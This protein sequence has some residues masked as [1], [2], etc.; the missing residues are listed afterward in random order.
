MA[1]ST[2]NYKLIKPSEDDFYDVNQ[3]NQNADM[4]DQGMKTNQEQIEKMKRTIQARLLASKWS[5]TAP[6]TQTVSVA[7][8]TQ[9]DNPVMLK[10]LTGSESEAVVKA[11]NKAYGFLVSGETRAGSIV[12]TAYKK[13]A[14]DFDIILKGV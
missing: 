1:D 7:G 10:A 3:F 9:Q 2:Q 14:I 13:P 4:I 5:S 6:F 12:V 8:I 11:Y